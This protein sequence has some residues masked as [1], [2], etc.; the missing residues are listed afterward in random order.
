M[1]QKKYVTRPSPP[2]PANDYCG[3]KKKGND[4]NMYISTRDKNGTCKWIKEKT[5]KTQK[6][7][8]KTKSVL[9]LFDVVH[10]NETRFTNIVEKSNHQQLVNLQLDRE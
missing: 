3:K 10:V 4:G 7:T 5:K 1:T 9:D 8:E 6:K 2:Y